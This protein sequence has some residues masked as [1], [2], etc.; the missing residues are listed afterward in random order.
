[1]DSKRQQKNARM[2]Q[3]E[4]GQIFQF[5]L[6]EFTSSAFI[7]ISDVKVTPDLKQAKVYLRFLNAKEPDKLLDTIQARSWHIRRQLAQKIRNQ[8]K[9][10]PEL[11][12]HLDRSEEE[13]EKMEQLFKNLNNPLP[14]S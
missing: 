2:I 12:F 7:T 6:S 8:V 10:I 1:M 14:R 5:D 4:I 13:A 11:M 3:K 9:Y